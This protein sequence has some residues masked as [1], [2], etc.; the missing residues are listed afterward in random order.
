M[1]RDQYEAIRTAI[2]NAKF[3]QPMDFLSVMTAFEELR[4]RDLVLRPYLSTIRLALVT[5]RNDMRDRGLEGSY[6]HREATRAYAM[7]DAMQASY[8]VQA[9]IGDKTNSDSGS[10]SE[11]VNTQAVLDAVAKAVAEF[12]KTLPARFSGWIEQL[13]CVMVPAKPNDAWRDG[14]KFLV[15]MMTGVPVSNAE[16]N[17][18]IE[19]LLAVAPKVKA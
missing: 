12:E 15:T 5:Q 14:I 1:N 16:A 11:N 6:G 4:Q 13:G 2:R 17:V 3:N 18:M 10:D 9:S 19:S 8:S 7:I